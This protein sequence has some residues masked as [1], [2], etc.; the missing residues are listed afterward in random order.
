MARPIPPAAAGHQRRL[1]QGR[2]RGHFSGSCRCRARA[3]ALASA[4]AE[5]PAPPA[6]ER[7]D[8]RGAEGGRAGV[9]VRQ[10]EIELLQ[11]ADLVAQPRRLLEFQIGG[12][13]AHFAFR[14]WRSPP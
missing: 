8:G 9:A 14:D 11:P 6:I 7:P 4:R 10:A 13:G 2:R 3:L 1:G 5:V 12:G